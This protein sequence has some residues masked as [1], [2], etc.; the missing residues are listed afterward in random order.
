MSTSC[1]GRY[2]SLHSSANCRGSAHVTRPEPHLLQSLLRMGTGVS[3]RFPADAASL[4]RAQFFHRTGRSTWW[5][6]VV[7][8]R[9]RSTTSRYLEPR[10][11]GRHGNV[12]VVQVASPVRRL[13]LR[14]LARRSVSHL[15]AR[16]VLLAVVL[17]HRDIWDRVSSRK[18]L[19]IY[20][21]A[22]LLYLEDKDHTF[23][24]VLETSLCSPDCRPNRTLPC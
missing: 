23:K 24:R 10:G 13:R 15:P 7:L 6:R 9:Q 2:D 8:L 12:L 21:I 1:G 18:E 4:F 16:S 11:P 17:R 20:R 22:M 5:R 19:T 14:D 3:S